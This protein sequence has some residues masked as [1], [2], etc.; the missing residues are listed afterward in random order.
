MDQEPPLKPEDAAT[1]RFLKILVTVLTATMILGLLTIVT[2]LVIR[3]G[4]T[5]EPAFPDN[6]ALPEGVAPRA[7]T[8]SDDWI[9]LVTDDG[10]ILI[11]P[12]EGGAPVQEI[13]V[14]L[15]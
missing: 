11:Y 13:T 2:L 8:R 9:A 12:A 1:L 14:T 7:I 3:L 4:P 5:P 6:L 10:R 15:P